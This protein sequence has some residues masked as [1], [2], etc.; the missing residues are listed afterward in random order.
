MEG[1]KSGEISHVLKK[2]EERNVEKEK[3]DEK[4]EKTESNKEKEKKRGI[5]G[6]K[7]TMKR[8]RI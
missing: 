2:N 4:E 6:K 3:E 7:R 5:G 8:R 1:G